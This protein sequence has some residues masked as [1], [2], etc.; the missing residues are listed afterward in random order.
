MKKVLKFCGKVA[1]Y[2]VK[3]SLL[4]LA[5]ILADSAKAKEHEPTLHE[6]T[7]GEKMPFSDQYYIP[8]E[9]HNN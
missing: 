1:K 7:Y 5:G 2:S 3:F 4:L 9:K 8:D 6:L